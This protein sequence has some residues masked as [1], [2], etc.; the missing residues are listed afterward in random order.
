[1]LDEDNSMQTVPHRGVSQLRTHQRPD[2]AVVVTLGVAAAALLHALLL[3]P[4]L[5]GG[6]P[7]ARHLSNEQGDEAGGAPAMTVINLEE[8]DNT[9]ASGEPPEASLASV[10]SPSRFLMPVKGI[11]PATPRAFVALEEADFV[12]PASD[13]GQE[14][15]SGHALMFGRYL[16]QVTARVERAWIRPRSSI[17]EDAF[18]CRVRVE[19]DAQRTVKDVTLQGCNGTPVWQQSLVRAIESASPLPAPPDP[20]VFSKVLVFDMTSEGFQKGGS[21]EGFEPV[22]ILTAQA[23]EAA[24]SRDAFERTLTQ[25]RQKGGTGVIDLRITGSAQ[26][27]LPSNPLWS[28]A[29]GRRSANREDGAR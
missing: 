22:P 12:Q 2:R 13:S 1:M 25:L 6:G 19:Q 5:I 7:R 15:E 24:E 29:S 10:I 20:A 3:T 14:E 28:G 17:G 11:D 8:S 16:G 18:A 21:E 4:F 9:I 27:A 23:A 26:Q